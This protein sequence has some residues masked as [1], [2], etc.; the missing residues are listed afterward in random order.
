MA[1]IYLLRH[2]EAV[3]HKDP[4]YRTDA[5]RPLTE[6]GA[7]RMRGAAEGMKRLGLKFDWILTSPFVRAMETARIVAEVLDEPDR[8]RVEESLASGARWDRVKK[9]ITAGD[10]RRAESI[11]L[12]GHEP[13]LSR[14]AADLIQAGR[15][16]LVM[17]KGSLA[18]V[19][20]DGIPP[21]EPGSLTFLMSIDHLATIAG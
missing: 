8:L 14:M 13:D 1:S 9:A 15:A 21:K 4:R 3:P 11:L 5:D 18:C 6:S 20:V 10:A 2:A 16:S 17:K 7:A 12:A 19:A